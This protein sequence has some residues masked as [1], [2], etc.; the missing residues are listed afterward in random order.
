MVKFSSIWHMRLFNI[1]IL[2]QSENNV[3]ASFIRI[4]Y[5]E[6]TLVGLYRVC[7]EG[8]S[9]DFL[10]YTK[11][12]TINKKQLCVLKTALPIDIYV[13]GYGESITSPYTNTL[14]PHKYA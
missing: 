5:N 7:M 9:V 12:A 1:N 6:D 10:L 3:S 11:M 14:C 2:I 8:G 13:S 4:W